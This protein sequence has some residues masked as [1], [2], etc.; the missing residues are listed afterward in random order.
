M[1][2]DDKIVALDDTD[3]RLLLAQAEVLDTAKKN[4]EKARVAG[5][6]HGRNCRRRGG[7]HEP[8]AE[9]HYGRR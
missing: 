7:C 5:R 9:P 2:N 1:S 8:L 6:G 3:V 4:A